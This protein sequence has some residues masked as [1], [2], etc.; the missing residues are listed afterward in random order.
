MPSEATLNNCA[1]KDDVTLRETLKNVSQQTSEGRD[2][3]MRRRNSHAR[4]LEKVAYEMRQV[5]K[6]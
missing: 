2:T 3:N 4:E 5:R 1:P 6:G